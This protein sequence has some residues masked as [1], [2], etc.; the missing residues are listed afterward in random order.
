MVGRDDRMLALRP[1]LRIAV[2]TRFDLVSVRTTY[3]VLACARLGHD[4]GHNKPANLA[5]LC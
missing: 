5:P 3:V 1:R 2:W 4:P